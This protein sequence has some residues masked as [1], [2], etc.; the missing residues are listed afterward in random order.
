MGFPIQSLNCP[1]QSQTKK[2]LDGKVSVTTIT[3]P[4]GA[5]DSHRKY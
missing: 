1:V 2:C 4:P 5:E 3:L